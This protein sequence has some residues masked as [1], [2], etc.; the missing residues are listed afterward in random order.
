M[1]SIVRTVSPSGSGSERQGILDRVRDGFRSAPRWTFVLY[2]GLLAFFGLFFLL[3]IAVAVRGAFL[4]QTGRL[5]FEYI[6]EVFRN[7]IYL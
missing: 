2:L 6:F 3:P 5:T 1:N 7:P 4:D